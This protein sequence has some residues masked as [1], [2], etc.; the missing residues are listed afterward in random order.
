MIRPLLEFIA[1]V[2]ILSWAKWFAD[3]NIQ[4]ELYG[5]V[6]GLIL[7]LIIGAVVWIYKER[8]LLL[9]YWQCYRS[10]EPSELRLTFAYLYKIE[11]NGRYLLVKSNRFNTYQ[12]VG[13]V[14]KYFHPETVREF[15]TIGVVPDNKIKNDADSEHDIRL[16]L[17]KKKNLRKFFKWFFRKE[18]RETDPWR[19][20]YEELVRPGIVAASKFGYIHYELVGQHIEPIHMDTFFNIDTLKY[21]DVYIPKFL[22]NEQVE[23]VRHLQTLSHPNPDYIWVTRQEIMQGLSDNGYSIAEHTRKIFHNKMLHQ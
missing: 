12:P 7:S 1:L 9:I 23:E 6:I 4:S 13:G 19:E 17:Q 2:I 15:H 10:W 16:I 21:V 20:F 3:D 8:D 11:V 5:I 14:Y 18:N 22:N